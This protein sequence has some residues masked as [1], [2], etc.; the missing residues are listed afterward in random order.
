MARAVS[1]SAALVFAAAVALYLPTARFGFVED[2]RAIIT[3]NP[4]AHSIGAAL[5]A[6]GRP[7]WPPPSEAGLYRP[8]AIL[9]YAADWSLS[10]GRPGWLHLMNA[11]WHGLAAALVVLVVARWL[12]EPGAWAAGLVFALHPVHVEGVA[13]L[14]SRTELLA[15]AAMLGA[16]LAARRHAWAVAVA[17]ALA[18]CLSKE[19]GVVTGVVILLDDWL[20]PAGARRYPKGFYVALA[21]VTV[22]FLAAWWQIGHQAVADVAPPFLHGGTIRRLAIALPAL[23]RG[24]GLLVWPA[25]LSADYNPQVLPVPGGLTPPAVAGAMVVAGLLVLAFR[26]RRRAPGASFA[27]LAAACAYLPTSNLLFPSGIVLAERNLYFPVLVAAVF[28]GYGVGWLGTCWDQRRVGYVLAILSLALAARS[29]A[30]LPAWR[31]NRTFVLTLLADHP[32]SY[33]AHTWA[34]AVL[35]GIGDTAGARREFGRADSLYGGDPHLKAAYA[36]FLV[37]VGDT[38]RAAP[39]AAA[40]RA[41]LPRQFAALRVQFLLALERGERARALALADTARTWFPWEDAWYRQRAQ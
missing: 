35:A 22:A 27:A 37:E 15:A 20:Q 29:Y 6:F 7:Y 13:S 3:S 38:T 25:N 21:G 10:G 33:R 18:A 19:Y 26:V 16:V 1:R 11:L 40:A 39:L 12:R 4:A 8:L 31:D 36:F 14:V 23:A 5:R 41:L 2:D 34:A 30:R 24:A 28:V 32:E 9:T 17:C